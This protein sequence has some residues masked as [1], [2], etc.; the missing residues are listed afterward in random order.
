MRANPIAITGASGQVGTALQRRL[1]QAAAEV[2]ALGR[3]DDLRSAVTGAGAVV[4]LAGALRPGRGN[5]Y[6][7]ANV[8]TVRRTVAA[9]N[10]SSVRRVV[11]LS[12]VGADPGAA[13]AYVRT[14]GE[15][16]QLLLRSGREVTVFRC[17]HIF[18]P[19][20]EPGPTVQA[21]LARR[22]KPIPV[23]GDGKQCWAPVYRDDVVEAIVLALAEDAPAGRFDLPGPEVMTVD[24]LVR[25]VNRD[26]VR[27]RHIPNPLAQALGHLVPTLTPALADILLADSLADPGPVEAAYGLPRRDLAGVYS[28]AV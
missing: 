25:A 2:R 28:A 10:G 16:E 13:N 7:A 21:F 23:L 4:H 20:D 14:K 22:K 6:R 26:D 1:E 3:A 19:P 24:D 8:E 12:Y 18:G 17:T 15:A 9:L 5:S 11:F 27:L